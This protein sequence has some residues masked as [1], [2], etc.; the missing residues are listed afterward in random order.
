MNQEKENLYEKAKKEMR[1]TEKIL[2]ELPGFR[3]YKQKELRRETDKLIRNHIY[4]KL[5]QA[6]NNIK[7]TFQKLANQP[8]PEILTSMDKLVMKIDRITEKIN[9]ATY[10][11]SGFFN[12]LKIQEEKLD[13][14]IDFDTK[15]IE[16]TQNI[17]NQTQTFKQEITNQKFEKTKEH[18]QKLNNSLD[19]LEQTFDQRSETVLGVT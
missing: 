5:T 13:K 10:G 14:M 7:E 6:K 16:H 2:A 18:I 17:L 11:Y 3:G 19:T 8:Q 15:L 9:H 12:I 4:Q 1:L